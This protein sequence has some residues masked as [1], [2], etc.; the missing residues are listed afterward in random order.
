[1]KHQK[2]ISLVEVL[3]GAAAMGI[4]G[5]I[6]VT[7][8]VN[9]SGILYSQNTKINQSLALNNVNSELHDTIQYAS[10]IV[11]SFVNGSNSFTTSASTLVFQMPSVLANGNVIDGKFDTIVISADQQKPQLLKK[12]IYPDPSSSRKNETATLISNLSQIH[13]SYL[14]STGATVTPTAAS[15][16]EYSVKIAEKSSYGSKESSISGSVNLRN[17]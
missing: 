4:I 10:S 5:T 17:N 8:M 11:G 7:I 3:L 1:M 12:R 15:T 14:S 9:G 13:F 6:L 2:G 16:I